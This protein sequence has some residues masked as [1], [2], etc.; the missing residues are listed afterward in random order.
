MMAIG[1]YMAL[2]LA[3]YDK[4]IATQAGA[5]G[6]EWFKDKDYGMFHGE[7]Q[8]GGGGGAAGM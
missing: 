7:Q 4:N 8:T 5:K 2:H 1:V 3:V 6:V